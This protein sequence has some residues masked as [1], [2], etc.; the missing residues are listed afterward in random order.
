MSLFH[1][2][3]LKRHTEH[4]QV[5]AEHIALLTN[6]AENLQSGVF[7]VE[8]QSDAR[9]IQ[10]IL[11]DVLGF[12][13]RG[14]APNWT[15]S[16]NQPVG[17][18][19]V[20]VALGNF[21]AESVQIIA[22]LELKGAKTKNLDA[23]YG[24]KRSPVQQAWDYANDNEGT[25]WVL[26]SNY[27]EIR[28]YAYGKGRKDYE[29]FDLTTLTVSEN[30]K[31]FIL[32]LSADN[33]LGGKTLSLLNESEQANK[34][35]TDKFYQEYKEFR[36][37]LI[38]TIGKDNRE[39]DKLDIIRYAQ[40]ILDRIL[41]VA[42]AESRDLL[43]K[44]TLQDAFTS[45]N[46]YNPLP[47]WKNFVGLFHAINEG[48]AELGITAYNG[49]LFA[50]DPELNDL[51]VRDELCKGFKKIGEHDF[52]TE[53]SVDILGHIFE[54]S[55]SDLEELKAAA[56]G[57]IGTLDKKKSKRK[58]DGVFYTPPY[59]TQ[60]IV[61]QTVGGWLAER[62][63]EIGFDTLP[64]LS[65]DDYESTKQ[66]RKKQ[67]RN[68]NIERHI[69]AWE[70]YKTALSNI[71]VLDPACGSGAFLI[72]VF[73]FLC[74]E[75][76]KINDEL[77]RLQGGHSLFRWDTHILSN[78]LYGVDLNRESVE[79]TKLS[80]WLKTARRNEKLTYLENNIKVGNSL[81]DDKTVVGDLAF[82]WKEEFSDI[83]A[84]G[85]FDVVV[86]NPPYVSLEKI[87]PMSEMLAKSKYQTYEK[88]GDL[89]ML[90]VERGFQLLK[91]D[92]LISYIMSNKWM[93]ASYGKPLRELFLSKKLL[94][95]IDLGDIQLFKGATTYPCIFIAENGKPNKT[96][97]ASVLSTCKNND[98]VD[99]IRHREETF[100]LE[101]FSGETWII[102]SQKDKKLVERL[103]NGCLTLETF[104]SGG[105]NYGIKTGLTKAFLIDSETQCRLIAENANAKEV[106]KPFLQGRDI[107]RYATP[108]N[109]SSLVFFPK[110]ATLQNAKTN[111]EK[112]GWS[113]LS[114]QYPSIANWLE[115]YAESGR[116][117]T[118]QGDFWW[119]L[120]ACDYYSH[121][122]KPKIM[123]QKFQV[124]PCFIYDEKGLYCNDSM[125]IIPTDN[126]ALLAILNSRMGWWLVT[127]Y[128]TQ[129]QNGYQLI[130][131]YFKRIPIPKELPKALENLAE[132]M[133]SLHSEL[134]NQRQRFQNLVSDN[135]GGVKMPDKRFDEIEEFK[136]FLSELKKQKRPIPLNEQEGWRTA[137]YE[138]KGKIS[139]LRASIRQTD[140]DID[141]MV[142]ELY[143]LTRTEIETI[144]NNR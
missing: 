70:A 61:E 26:V 104:I 42:F 5:D 32:L 47:I 97:S 124:K 51:I 141:R 101:Q 126:N 48:N 45:V 34:D 8:T 38:E 143:G 12:V 130:W 11:I 4:I 79:I 56:E 29:T 13:G 35:I 92:G 46:R 75:G 134:Q 36:V 37:R 80:L 135:L 20:D 63:K 57:T 19:N 131:Q 25:K 67:T 17:N 53:I 113:W 64:L 102:S 76:K 77:A 138:S 125:W 78:N 119:E 14:D 117:R 39:K 43:P 107:K 100:S 123:Y 136:D 83:M 6:W 1:P 50:D 115:P 41:F 44:K 40:K 98:F 18:G 110:G 49:G 114:N 129:I 28:L 90:F 89:Y 60:Y 128:C 7:D 27:R 31:R 91:Q 15:L 133:L 22:P 85:G 73:D 121:F 69:A 139:A 132:R 21:T 54:Q 127:K 116:K 33:L 71:K 106:M 68:D 30:Y 84:N 3:V 93:Q 144:E 55:I 66:G 59:I 58:T 137:F 82:V 72:E 88:R 96:F 10:R 86:G 142:Y 108:M 81:I 118:D 87:K 120:R 105:A 62:R 112:E 23:L 74:R 122:A 111:D 52:D 140:G 65:D 94:R 109:D 2:R 24:T 103:K 99:Q 16:K 95:L 9:F